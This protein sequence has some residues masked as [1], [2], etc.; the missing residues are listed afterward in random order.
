MNL[1]V[2]PGR[3][4]TVRDGEWFFGF[5]DAILKANLVVRRNFAYP[6]QFEA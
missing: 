1:R 2:F 4:T 5:R 6:I 3:R